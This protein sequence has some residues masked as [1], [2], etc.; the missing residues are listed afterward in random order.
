[1]FDAWMQRVAIEKIREKD[2][3][4]INPE[5]NWTGKGA[6]CARMKHDMHLCCPEC[7][8]VVEESCR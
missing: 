2:F 5:C 3:E 6:D 4:C 8:E 7:Y 1:M